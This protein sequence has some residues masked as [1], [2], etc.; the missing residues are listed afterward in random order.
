VA[1]NKCFASASDSKKDIS[2]ECENAVPRGCAPLRTLRAKP[3]SGESLLAQCVSAGLEHPSPAALKGRKS[4]ASV[5]PSALD[6]IFTATQRSRTGLGD[7][8]RFA[9]FGLLTATRPQPRGTRCRAPW[10]TPLALPKSLLQA[11]SER[12]R[13][14]RKR[15]FG[16][17]RQVPRCRG[18][19]A[20]I[21]ARRFNAGNR[22]LP[23]LAS[24]QRRQ[25]LARCLFDSPR[26][27]RDSLGALGYASRRSN[28]GLGSKRRY[29]DADPYA[30]IQIVARLRSNEKYY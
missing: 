12:S 5:A 25:M 13:L 15:P 27:W 7:S 29:R 8:R 9:A 17:S 6:R 14:F 23:S 19:D 24:R 16:L 3:R 18:S 20:W 4:E 22:H 1:C 11:T 30:S 21:L 26:R 28:A 10:P 2:R